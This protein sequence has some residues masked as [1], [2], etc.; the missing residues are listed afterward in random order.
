MASLS[1]RVVK[2]SSKGFAHA[3]T[4]M[5][6]L[7]ARVVKASREGLTHAGM[8]TMTLLSARVVKASSVGL[9]HAGTTLA[10]LIARVVKASSEW[11][12]HAGTD[13]ARE[14]VGSRKSGYCSFRISVSQLGPFF[15]RSVEAEAAL[16]GTVM[17]LLSARV[18]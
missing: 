14:T 7:S 13:H 16:R 17:A 12:T 1:A 15:S 2:A 18:V 4:K 5:A 8:T 10:L 6:L 11:L 3:G 9:M